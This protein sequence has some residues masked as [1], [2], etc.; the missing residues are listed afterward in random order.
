M[1]LFKPFKLPTQLLLGVIMATLFGFK[2]APPPSR[3]FVTTSG[4]VNFVSEAPL[5]LIKAS[6]DKLAGA[7]D[8]EKR[9]FA[10][11]IPMNSFEGFNDPLQK[12]HFCEKFLECEKF[13]YATFQGRLIENISFDRDGEYRV[14]TKGIL[15]IH[16]IKKERIIPVKISLKGGQMMAIAQ[17]TVLLEDHE[18][19]VPQIVFQKIAKEINVDIKADLQ[20]RKDP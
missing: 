20:L 16:G 12:E 17:F 10:F 5:E 11:K 8:S 6:S 13:A 1:P 15:E 7:F 14:R 9:N 3:V 4:Q 2:T 19:K 18:I